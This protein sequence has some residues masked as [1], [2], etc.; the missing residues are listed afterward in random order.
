MQSSRGGI[1]SEL[2]RGSIRPAEGPGEG[3]VEASAGVQAVSQEEVEQDDD[4][5]TKQ[6]I[7]EAIRM[8]LLEAKLQ[9]KKEPDEASSHNLE[10]K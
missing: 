2:M 7:E 3:G 8:S 10:H 4:E 5:V 9:E 1:I 6:M